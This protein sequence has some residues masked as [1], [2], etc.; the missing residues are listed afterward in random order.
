[1]NLKYLFGVVQY[2]TLMRTVRNAPLA[3]ES[4]FSHGRLNT[5]ED[6]E[7]GMAQD[8]YSFG[9]GRP[10]KEEHHILPESVVEDF[11]APLSKVVRPMFDLIWN[12]CGFLKV[13]EF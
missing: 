13:Q 9:G 1:L 11:N 12:A 5:N 7:F 4:A 3:V 6:K 8:I 10:I 2:A